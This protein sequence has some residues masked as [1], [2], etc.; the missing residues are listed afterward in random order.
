[1]F[2]FSDY[3]LQDSQFVLAGKAYIYNE[4]LLKEFPDIDAIE[5]E[6]ESDG[7]GAFNSNM[8]K[9]C[10]PYWY[11]WSN[12]RVEE[13]EI[14]H[15]VNGDG[16]SKLDGSFGRL[17]YNFREAVN[18]RVMDIINAET[19]LAAYEGSGGIRGATA[20]ILQPDR[21]K[22]LEI[23]QNNPRLL[24]SHRLVLDR[25]KREIRS[26][27][28]SGYGDGISISFD[29]IDAMWLK[30]SSEER[31]V[32]GVA[33]SN[34]DDEDHHLTREDNT[35]HPKKP[36]YLITLQKETTQSKDKALHPFESHSSRMKKA[37]TTKRA[38]TI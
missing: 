35:N 22:K 27:S 13:V 38:A 28:N 2:F 19:C 31:M 7:A 37:K 5:T 18:N 16:K 3:T 4:F 26:Y 10:M 34:E 12:G 24:S 23:V 11:E 32:A 29:D 33:T 20:A 14:R 15:C 21:T 30:A 1:M 17:G 36:G 25:S 6:F 8:V 9:A